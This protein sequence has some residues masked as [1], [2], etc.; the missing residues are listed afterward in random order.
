MSANETEMD[1]LHEK[2]KASEEEHIAKLDE[3]MH[4]ATS[5]A[6]EAWAYGAAGWMALLAVPHLLFPRLL[7]LMATPE[8]GAAPEHHPLRLTQLES[9]FSL[10][11]GVLLITVA[12]SVIISIPNA[13][14]GEPRPEAL[15]HPLLT[16]LSLGLG[17]MSF[18]S[19]H[20]SLK[21]LGALPMIAAV[22]SGAISLW[23]FWVMFFASEGRRSK[24]TGADKRTSAFLF[25]NKAAASEQKKEYRRQTSQKKYE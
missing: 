8:T 16:P 3:Q 18:A 6:A 4:H 13:S 14:P 11:F 5:P 19:Y 23:G 21:G 2:A 22:G 15:Q 9:F 1:N 12:L 10:H 24:K 17:V 25:G 7:V 20:T